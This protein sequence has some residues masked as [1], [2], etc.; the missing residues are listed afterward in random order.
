[1]AHVRSGGAHAQQF[2]LAQTRVAALD[3]PAA[4]GALLIVCVMLRPVCCE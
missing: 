2:A 3:E 4:F 1:M